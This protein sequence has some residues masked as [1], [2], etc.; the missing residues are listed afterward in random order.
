MKT[1]TDNQSTSRRRSSSIRKFRFPIRYRALLVIA[2]SLLFLPLAIY[3][4]VPSFTHA[5]D[6]MIAQLFGSS[7]PGGEFCTREIGNFACCTLYLEA[8]PCMEGCRHEYLNQ[9][10]MELGEG[11]EG[12]EE[13][14]LSGYNSTCGAVVQREEVEMGLRGV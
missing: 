13:G 5:T 7:P 3:Q 2:L 11:Y 9:E 14:C 1:T 12:C 8:M 4:L 10:T 6:N